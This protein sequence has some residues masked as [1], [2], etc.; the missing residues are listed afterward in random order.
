MDHTIA[1]LSWKFCGRG[2]P[3]RPAHVRFG[4]EADVACRRLDVRFTPKRRP[5]L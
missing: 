3:V 4:S 2:C 5:R 1:H